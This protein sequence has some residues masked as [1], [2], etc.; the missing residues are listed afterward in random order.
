MIDWKSEYEWIESYSDYNLNEITLTEGFK[1]AVVDYIEHIIAINLYSDLY[2]SE[3][4]LVVKMLEE[5]VLESSDDLSISIIKELI[6][7]KYEVSE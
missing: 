6:E 2:Y 7:D 5:E 4:I 3:L 1:S